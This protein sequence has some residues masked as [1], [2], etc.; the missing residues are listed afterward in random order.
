MEEV[1]EDMARAAMQVMLVGAW[2]QAGVLVLMQLGTLV[3]RLGLA[4]P[5]AA[6]ARGALKWRV[7]VEML[8]MVNVHDDIVSGLSCPNLLHTENPC[9]YC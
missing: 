1:H 8:E 3:R 9:C 6:D 7:A 2:H 4:I 5:D